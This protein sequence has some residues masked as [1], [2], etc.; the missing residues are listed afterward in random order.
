MQSNQ[1]NHLDSSTMLASVNK[2]LSLT[3]VDKENLQ[4]TTLMMQDCVNAFVIN[5]AGEILILENQLNGRSWDSWRV[6]G[7]D[8]E[9]GED[10]IMTVQQNLRHQTG[11]VCEDWIYLGTYILSEVQE[12]GAS[13]FFCAQKV[14]SITQPHVEYRHN[15]IRWIS[16]QELKQAL[17]DGRIA[18]MNHAAAICLAIVLCE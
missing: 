2:S 10:P 14:I 15:T 4:S 7:C 16:K 5:E 8:L 9:N 1:P 3:A 12:K 13:H 11:L 18:M 17:L 6:V